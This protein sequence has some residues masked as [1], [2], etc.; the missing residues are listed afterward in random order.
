MATILTVFGTGEGQT[1]EIADSITAEFSARGHTATTVNVVDI[2]SELDPDEFD[3]VLVGASVHYGRQQTSVRRWVKTNRDVLVRKPNGFFQV[4]G[5]SGAKNDEGLAEAT[6]YL[7]KF[8]DDTDWRPDRIA[9]FG[10]ALRFSEYGFLKRALLKFIV[11]NQEF[12]TD[13]SGD[14]ELTDWESVV[15][16]ADEFAVFVEERLGEAVETD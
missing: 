8:I 7:D 13:E 15:S 3:A 11:R 4:S 1:A 12:E 2:D 10:G 14:A 16:F 5:A 9:L 6:G